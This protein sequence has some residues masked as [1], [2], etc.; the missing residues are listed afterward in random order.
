MH[1][2]KSGRRLELSGDLTLIAP[3]RPE[4]VPPVASH[5]FPFEKPAVEKDGCSLKTSRAFVEVTVG[6]GVAL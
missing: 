2:R 4:P 6:G 5:P 3:S 1:V